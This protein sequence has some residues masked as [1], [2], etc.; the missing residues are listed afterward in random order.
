M[1]GLQQQQMTL[2]VGAPASPAEPQ[3][4]P[5]PRPVAV[6]TTVV[7][8]CECRAKATLLVGDSGYCQPC[9]IRALRARKLLNKTSTQPLIL[10]CDAGFRRVTRAQGPVDFQAQGEIERVQICS[11]CKE[12]HKVGRW[13]SGTPLLCPA[14]SFAAYREVYPEGWQ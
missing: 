4:S 13:S 8:H 7:L 2:F 6:E 3:P 12:L 9:L 10:R 11:E 1:T 14:C 5:H